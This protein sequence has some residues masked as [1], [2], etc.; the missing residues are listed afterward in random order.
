MAIGAEGSR[1]V[2]M[3]MRE[4]GILTSIG[5]V[6]GAALALATAQVAKSL[7][8]GLK[9]RDPW[10]LALAVVTLS[11]VAALASF[12]PAYRAS[13]LDPMLALRDE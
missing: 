3:I 4:A 6:V 2:G 10:T 12:L 9:P 11:T 13:K 1:V 7:L 8:F 5:L